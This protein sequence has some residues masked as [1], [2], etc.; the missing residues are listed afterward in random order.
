MFCLSRNRYPAA[1][2]MCSGRMS[3]NSARSAIVLASLMILVHARADRP[4]RSMICSSIDLHSAVRGQYFSI[5]L[6]SIAALQTIFLPVSPVLAFSSANLF[7]WISLALSTLAAMTALLS[8]GLLCMSFLAST[9]ETQS[10]T[11]ILSMIGPDS[12]DI[13]AI[14]FEG[15]HVQR[16]P[17]P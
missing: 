4:N 1:S 8:A 10:C 9:L 2:E 12:L 16:S 3:G 5:Y 15:V 14:L 7:I 6:L 11:S 13:Y 17:S